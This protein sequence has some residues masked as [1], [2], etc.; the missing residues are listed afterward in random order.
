M[1]KALAALLLA[2]LTLLHASPANADVVDQQW[3]AKKPAKN[4]TYILGHGVFSVTGLD[5]D[6]YK[7][8][9][10]LTLRGQVIDAAD[11][12]DALCT[13]VVFRI[14]YYDYEQALPKQTRRQFRSCVPGNRVRLAFEHRD[15]SKLE[16]KVCWT[17]MGA[18]PGRECVDSWQPIFTAFP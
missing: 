13:W 2:A 15:V 4:G 17:E 12:Q 3:L 14:T 11:R 8:T 18:L 5:P 9:G 16:V 10:Q 1:R 6:R 7:P